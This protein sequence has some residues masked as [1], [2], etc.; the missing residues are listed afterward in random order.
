[1]Y[2][3]LEQIIREVA[4]WGDISKIDIY[5]FTFMKEIK[6]LMF[7]LIEMAH[8]LSVPLEKLLSRSRIST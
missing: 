2:K 8:T 3:S 5:S 7:H 6:S 1:M 4:T